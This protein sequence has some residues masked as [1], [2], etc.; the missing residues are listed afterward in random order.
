MQAVS[1]SYNLYDIIEVLLKPMDKIGELIFY[2][3]CIVLALF[4]IWG[5]F[6]FAYDYRAGVYGTSFKYIILLP[7]HEAGHGLFMLFWNFMNIS[8]CSLFQLFTP[9]WNRHC[10]LLN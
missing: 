4:A 6:L 1:S 5:W 8:D 7:I 2:G 9:L 3:R 10:L